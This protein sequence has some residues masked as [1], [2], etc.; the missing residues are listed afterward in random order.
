[1]IVYNEGRGALFH[2]VE[3]VCLTG[4]TALG[5]SPTVMT[6]YSADGEAWSVPRAIPAGT[7]GER[8]KRLVWVG[9]GPM[10]HWRLQ[11]FQGDSDAF[12]AAARLEIRAEALAV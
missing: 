6:S 9:M 4:R 5:L 7:R 12:L 8:D 2:E 3:L 11:R 1:M 10:R